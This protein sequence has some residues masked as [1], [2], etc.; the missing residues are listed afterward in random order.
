MGPIGSGLAL[1]NALG[2][3]ADKEKGITWFYEHEISRARQLRY[4]N[5]DK[6]NHIK[7]QLAH[8]A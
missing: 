6:G 7:K 3:Y 5:W 8:R 2:E 4:S 1:V